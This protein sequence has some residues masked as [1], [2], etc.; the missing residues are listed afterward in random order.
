MTH[1]SQNLFLVIA[2]RFLWCNIYN[3]VL[4]TVVYN[5]ACNQR[6]VCFVGTA[7]ACNCDE[8]DYTTPVLPSCFAP[9]LGNCLCS[10][11]QLMPAQLRMTALHWLLPLLMHAAL[12]QYLCCCT[13]ALL[14][15]L[16]HH[17]ASCEPRHIMLLVQSTSPVSLQCHFLHH[18]SGWH[19]CK[20]GCVDMP[21]QPTRLGIEFL[22]AL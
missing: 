15:C 5:S 16:R 22:P 2:V 12:R 21:L 14:P 1:L 11:E 4:Y 7:Y 18:V 13:R 17:S 10:S 8:G 20:V 6:T 19:Y 3:S 9:C